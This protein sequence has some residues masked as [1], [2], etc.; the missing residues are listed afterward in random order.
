M[1]ESADVGSGM[2]PSSELGLGIS[3]G[4]GIVENRDD[5]ECSACSSTYELKS[6]GD[7]SIL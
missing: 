6:G 7:L 4:N 3:T 5:R 1:T 2:G